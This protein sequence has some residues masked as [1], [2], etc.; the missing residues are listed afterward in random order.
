M[1]DLH[2]F[3]G[4]KM[5]NVA[6]TMKPSAHSAD[7]DEDNDDGREPASAPQAGS[8][9]GEQQQ[10]STLNGSAAA[11]K[12]SKVPVIGAG[13]SAKK[14]KKRGQADADDPYKETN[15]RLVQDALAELMRDFAPAS[16]NNANDS[17]GASSSDVQLTDEVTISNRQRRILHDVLSYGA[18]GVLWLVPAWSIGGRHQLCRHVVGVGS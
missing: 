8:L 13:Q 4:R 16:A 11:K 18:V 7:E 2:L 6:I 3:L 14:K 10:T 12:P 9:S 17:S 5:Q 15:K 1:V